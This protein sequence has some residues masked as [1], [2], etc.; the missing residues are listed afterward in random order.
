MDGNLDNGFEISR[1]HFGEGPALIVW[2]VFQRGDITGFQ[3]VIH[4]FMGGIADSSRKRAR[5]GFVR[6]GQPFFR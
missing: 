5:F 2:S 4:L 3:E 1:D 6:L